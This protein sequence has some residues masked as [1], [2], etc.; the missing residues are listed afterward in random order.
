MKDIYLKLLTKFIAKTFKKKYS[1]IGFTF[2]G[3]IK[4]IRELTT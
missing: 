1:Q 4:K 3:E 2:L